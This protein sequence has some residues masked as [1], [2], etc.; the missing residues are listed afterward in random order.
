[1]ISR[2]SFVRRPPA[3]VSP[4][5]LSFILLLGVAS[6]CLIFYGHSLH[7]PRMSIRQTA[8]AL[9][10]PV[11]WTPRAPVVGEDFPVRGGEGGLGL[12]PFALA[13]FVL[14]PAD[15][16]PAMQLCTYLKSEDG[17]MDGV[18]VV[19]LCALG[20]DTPAIAAC[21]D[22]V[23]HI[24]PILDGLTLIR[25]WDALAVYERAI[26]LPLLSLVQ[27]VAPLHQLL[28]SSD[29][30]FAAT[31]LSVDPL[32]WDTRGVMVIEPSGTIFHEILA[33]FDG[34]EMPPEPL[35]KL[36]GRLF[37]SGDGGV[38]ALD[39]A[40]SSKVDT[41]SA[42]VIFSDARPPW[43]NTSPLHERWNGIDTRA[44]RIFGHARR[45]PTLSAWRRAWN[46]VCFRMQWEC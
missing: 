38:R 17:F 31:V 19:A 37:E 24:A 13:V 9:A 44:R 7:P 39:P 14:D 5:P 2:P 22:F 15:E 42:V 12:S 35:G 21:F 26:I 32:V 16:A 1:M 46:D 18:D 36:L 45:P 25:A 34:N 33:S 23:Y 40:V 11:V 3:P 28:Q 20:T 27:N 30:H 41:T 10:P 4:T 29:V 6:F 8:L 43:V